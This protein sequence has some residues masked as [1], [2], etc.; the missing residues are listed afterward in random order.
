MFEGHD[1]KN[2]KIFHSVNFLTISKPMNIY[3]REHS[4]F[5]KLFYLPYL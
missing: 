3:L 2:Y 4:I 1:I 5:S